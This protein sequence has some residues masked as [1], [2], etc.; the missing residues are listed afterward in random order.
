V[1]Y[2]I[3]RVLTL[4][5]TLGLVGSFVE[6]MLLDHHEGA[7]Q[8]I[9]LVL[10][11]CAAGA[12]A[13]IIVQPGR[14]TVRAFQAM[15]CLLIVAGLVGI[16]LHFRANVEFQTEVDPGLHGWA[17]ISK[18]LQA[19]APPALA[20]ASLAQLGLLGLVVAYGHLKGEQLATE[21]LQ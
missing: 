13:A 11:V 2:R 3:R 18:A 21:R 9:P 17:L 12:C 14:S 5:L 19:K 6:L 16:G 15:M 4:L 8:M 10:L 20:P 1:N 7:A